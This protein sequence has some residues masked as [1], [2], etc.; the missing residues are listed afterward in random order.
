MGGV[1]VPFGDAFFEERVAF[2]EVVLD[3]GVLVVGE[4]ELEVIEF[5]LVVGVL[6]V[7]EGVLEGPAVHPE[8]FELLVLLNLFQYSI[9]NK[10]TKPASHQKLPDLSILPS[11]TFPICP[12]PPVPKRSPVSK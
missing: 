5:G 7:E 4:G 10:H 9:Q 8:T 6:L 12:S 11:S 3:D 2:G 1:F